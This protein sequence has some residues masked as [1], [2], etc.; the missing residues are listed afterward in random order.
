VKIENFRTGRNGN[1]PRV[2]ATITWEDCGLPAQELYFETEEEFGQ[3]L[4]CNPHAFLVGCILPAMHHREKRIFLDAEICPELRDNLTTAMHWVRHWYYGA[5]HDLVKIEAGTRTCLPGPR[6]PERAGFFFSGGIDCL[7]TLRANRLNYPPEHPGSIRDGL[8]I[9]GQNIE[10]DNRPEI[11]AKA[12]ADLSEVTQESGVALIPVYTNI[13]LL[14]EG[15]KIF[16]INHGAILG[17]VA[18]AFSQRLTTVAISASDSIPGLRLVKSFIFKPHG[19]HPLLDPLYGSSDLRILHDGV[20]LSRLDKTK[21]IADWD[22]A[23]RNIK[24]CGPN[25]PGRNCG[26]CEK[27]VRTMLELLAAGVLGKSGAFP[28]D[29]VSAGLVTGINI[30]KPTFGYTADDDYLELVAPLREIG[31]LDLVNAIEEVVRRAHHR[32]S[33][34]SLKVKEFDRKYLSGILSRT[35]KIVRSGTKTDRS[36]PLAPADSGKSVDILTKPDR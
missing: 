22:T 12:Y 21:L 16:A 31:R 19:S 29:N 35:K 5:D 17:A 11:F 23:L 24:V 7:A 27:C 6:T 10:S 4:S 13:R 36:K 15:K 28:A 20:A 33:G 32:K 14:D 34:F 26:H 8:L 30:K 3:G 9:Y 18:H 1:R 2:T 25:W